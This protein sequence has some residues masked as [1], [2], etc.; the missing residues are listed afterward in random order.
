[1]LPPEPVATDLA[2]SPYDLRHAGVWLWFS[3]GVPPKQVAEWA[4]HS[5]EVLF[6]IY[7]HVLSGSPTTPSARWSRRR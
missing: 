3:S 2:A 4:G 1:M 5:L 6:R 7:A